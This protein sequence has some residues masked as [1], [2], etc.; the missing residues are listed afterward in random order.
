MTRSFAIALIEKGL[1]MSKSIGN[2]AAIQRRRGS[3]LK[4]W[5]IV[6]AT[7]VAALTI[8]SALTSPAAASS[9]TPLS[10]RMGGT[11]AESGCGFLTVCLAGDVHGIA[12]HLGRATLSKSVTV[13]LTFAASDGGGLLSTYTETAA[14]VAAN[15]DTLY[16]TGGGTACARSGRAVGTGELT[17]TGGTGHFAGASG[18]VSEAFDHSLIDGT[19][20]VELSGTLAYAG[21]SGS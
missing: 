12:T 4:R 10:A 13:R 17:I 6:G 7:I 18:S 9:P 11:L 20:I 1:T 2:S 16:L 3:A 19:E 21:G 5:S 15:G 8:A 14:L